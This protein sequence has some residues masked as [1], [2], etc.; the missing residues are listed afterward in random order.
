MKVFIS[1]IIPEEGLRLLKDAG[2]GIE[3][4]AEKRDLTPQELIDHCKS[5]DALLSAG[6]NKIDQAFLNSCS[7]LKVISLHSVGYDRVDVAAATALKIPVGNTPGVLS[8]ATAD[9]AFLLILATS[10][11][12]F[13]MHKTILDGDWNFF[14]PTAGLGIEIRG[15]TLGIFG[16]GKIG[17]E[18]AK[19]C[20][21][22]FQMKIIYHNRS[23]NE[24]AEKELNAQWVSFD[25]LLKQS[26]VLSVNTALTPETKGKFNRDV[27]EKMKPSSI[28][29]NAARGAIHNEPDLI[30]ALQKRTI[31]GAGLDV[32]DPEPMH[33]DNPLLRMPNVAVLPHIGSAT[34]ETRN[35]MAVIAA[36]NVIAGLKGQRLPFAVNPEVYDR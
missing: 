26:D 27:F 3:Q 34:V 19:C 22:A 11:K 23:R 31:W 15:K 17:L 10:R 8:D 2:I 18:L 9:I 6:G 33:S 13:Y 36:Q 5:V 12:A 24:A 7:H 25:D 1:R 21:A 30:A 16:L 14:E 20:A 4:W 29:I 28:F 35:A 32:T